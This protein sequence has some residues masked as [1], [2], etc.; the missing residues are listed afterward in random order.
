MSVR[1]RVT[2]NSAFDLIM[3]VK[4]IYN[5]VESAVGGIGDLDL[6]CFP[7]F[8]LKGFRTSFLHL[9]LRKSFLFADSFQIPVKEVIPDRIC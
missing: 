1:Y 8:F 7:K 2:R 3:L 4:S 5:I 6:N 9:R